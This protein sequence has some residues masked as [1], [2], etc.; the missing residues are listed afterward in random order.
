MK[1][2]IY[3]VLDA[4]VFSDVATGEAVPHLTYSGRVLGK[5]RILSTGAADATLEE[6]VGLCDQDAESRNA[7]DFCGTHRLLG[8]VL[9][10]QY[11]RES[12]TKTMREIALLGGLQGMSGVCCD[13]DAFEELR[14]GE[15]GCDWDGTYE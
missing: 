1:H 14:V 5:G 3:R 7:H 13:G 6:L 12:A 2:E 4:A 15:A 8:A 10:R 11:G 9:F